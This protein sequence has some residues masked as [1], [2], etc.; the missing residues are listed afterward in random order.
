MS[1]QIQIEHPMAAAGA[2]RSW[3]FQ[4][5]I[6]MHTAADQGTGHLRESDRQIRKLP[7]NR[8]SL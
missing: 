1:K 7:E 5:S 3:L 8:L 2:D 6:E 4:T